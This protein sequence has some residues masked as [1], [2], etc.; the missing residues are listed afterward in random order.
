MH[1]LYYYF[2][3]RQITGLDGGADRQVTTGS[4]L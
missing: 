4:R 3:V 2:F 1:S